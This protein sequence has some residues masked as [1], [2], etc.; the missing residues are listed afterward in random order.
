MTDHRSP[1][2]EHLADRGEQELDVLSK[3]RLIFEAAE[4]VGWSNPGEVARVR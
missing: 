2:P 3:A 4:Q 1:R